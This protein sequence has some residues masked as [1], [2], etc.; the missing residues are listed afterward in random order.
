MER[1]AL[2]FKFVEVDAT[3]DASVT[4]AVFAFLLAA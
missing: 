3:T 2:G 4:L 1:R